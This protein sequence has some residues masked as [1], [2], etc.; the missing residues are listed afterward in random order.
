MRLS[1]IL[2]GILIS[3]AGLTFGLQSM[4]VVG[5]PN[6]FMYKNPEWATNGIYIFAFGIVIIIIGSIL[7]RSKVSF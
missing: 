7:R 6:S 5:P 2:V 4:A 1:I 3:L